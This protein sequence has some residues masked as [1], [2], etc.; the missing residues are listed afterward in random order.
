MQLFKNRK[1]KQQELIE[2]AVSKT[3]DSMLKKRL[4]LPTDISGGVIRLGVDGIDIESFIYSIVSTCVTIRAENTANAN[5]Y[6]FNGDKEIEKH[7]IIELL[8]KQNIYGMNL[9][10]TLYF[11]AHNLDIYGNAY[12][13]IIR[14]GRNKPIELI[15]AVANNLIPQYN[16]TNTIITGYKINGTNTII[17]PANIIHFKIVSYNK[18][19]LGTPTIEN[20]KHIIKVDNLQQV[21]QQNYL[22]NMGRLSLLFSKEGPMTQE[23]F[24]MIREQINANFKGSKNAGQIAVLDEGFKVTEFGSTA[25]DAQMVEARNGIRKEVMSRMR[26]PDILMGGTEQ[27][28]GLAFSTVNAHIYVFTKYVI[29]PFSRFISDT[30]NNF[31]QLNYDKNLSLKFEYDSVYNP[32]DTELYDML[33]RNKVIDVSEARDFFGYDDKEIENKTE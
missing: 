17:P 1:L 19:L 32:A 24:E 29:Q 16:Q 21:F 27:G 20:L 18:L 10:Q 26:V 8:N 25:Q 28:G 11:I 9:Y 15:P 23:S 31:I 4:T 5:I 14:D 3:V 2:S 6:L 33:L 12:L 30:L 7:E 22:Q 13:I